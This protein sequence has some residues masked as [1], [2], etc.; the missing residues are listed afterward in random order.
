MP[1]QPLAPPLQ[2]DGVE[3]RMEK[4]VAQDETGRYYH[5]EKR[6]DFGKI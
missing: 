1:T 4:P 2:Q 6:L 3:N 5:G